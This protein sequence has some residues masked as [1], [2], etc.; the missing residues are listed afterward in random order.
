MTALSGTE[1]VVVAPDRQVDLH[2]AGALRNSIIAAFES[3][4]EGVVLDLTGVEFL[5]SAGIG[6]LVGAHRR[7]K[8]SGKA[9]RLAGVG[10]RVQRVLDL[11]GLVA[12]ES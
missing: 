3:D 2:N 12:L 4:T 9:F 7:A 6:I 5:D 1:T 11:T 8:A 10:P